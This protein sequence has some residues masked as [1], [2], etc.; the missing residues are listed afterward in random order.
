M[1]YSVI[2]HLG[3]FYCLLLNTYTQNTF[4]TI[5]WAEPIRKRSEKK[6]YAYSVRWIK[7]KT[8]THEFSATMQNWNQTYTVHTTHTLSMQPYENM[9]KSGL[10]EEVCHKRTRKWKMID[11]LV[12]FAGQFILSRFLRC[13]SFSLSALAR[14]VCILRIP[15]VRN[16]ARV[17]LF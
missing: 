5:K 3:T 11:K 2:F 9:Y 17:L 6:N 7:K 16:L 13:R 15:N 8:Q 10:V 1:E 4:Y 12:L 14:P